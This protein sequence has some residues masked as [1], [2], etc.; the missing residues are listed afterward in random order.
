[1]FFLPVFPL[2]FHLYLFFVL[3]SFVIFNAPD[4]YTAFVDIGRLFGVGELP[5][6]STEALYYLKSYGI[7]I[8]V[9]IIGCMPVIP[10][11]I[12]KL[13]EMKEQKQVVVL[14]ATLGV[15]KPVVLIALVVLSTA[16]LVDGSFNPFLYFRF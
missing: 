6:V 2:F 8:L 13:E 10:W 14:N 12:A 4:M 16:Y 15:L 1:M 5:F 3:L 7:T 11:F 9:G